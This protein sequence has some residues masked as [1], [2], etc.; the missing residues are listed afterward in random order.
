MGLS[1]HDPFV[2]PLGNPL[3]LAKVAGLLSV[4]PTVV[5]FVNGAAGDFIIPKEFSFFRVTVVGAGGSGWYSGGSFIYSYSG[6][7]GG[8]ARSAILPVRRGTTIS[9][10]AA[11]STSYTEK[12]GKPSTANFLNISLIATGGQGATANAQ[13]GM[14]SG[15]IDNYRGGN[16]V[17]NGNNS[18]AGAAG[19]NSNGA[20]SVS[21]GTGTAVAGL[22]SA[23]DGGG[24]GAARYQEVYG[25]GGWMGRGGSYPASSITPGGSPTNDLA[26]RS[27]TSNSGGN[28]GG[29]GAGSGYGGYGGVRIELW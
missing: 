4:N 15:G 5:D 14:G 21:V 22:N 3:G 23:G 12:N 20:D 26:A 7:G 16:V 29:G 11:P 17:S 2:D 9:Y 28:W 19:T 24:S 18:G 25:G 1:V 27:T 6:A 8:L 10:S 13:G